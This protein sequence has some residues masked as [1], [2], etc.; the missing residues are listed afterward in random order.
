VF[1]FL[2]TETIYLRL[3]LDRPAAGSMGQEAANIERALHRLCALS[4]GT[5]VIVR[6]RAMRVVGPDPSQPEHG[7][8]VLPPRQGTRINVQIVVE[9]VDK[10]RQ[11]I[12][13]RFA[14]LENW[15]KAPGAPEWLLEVEFNPTTLENGN[16]VLPATI[17]DPETGVL[18]R[19]PSSSPLVMQALNRSGFYFLDEVAKQTGDGDQALFRADTRRA[20]DRGYFE[21][22]R[23]QFCSY[24]QTPSV[25][26]FLQTMVIL[27]GQTIGSGTGV[28][29]LADYLGLL[30]RPFT[31]PNTNV[32][33][34]VMFQKFYGKKPVYSL[35]F[36][37]KMV[38]LAQMRQTT[39][40][41]RTELTTA[42]NNVRFDMTL[43]KLGILD[44]ISAAQTAL[45][46][47]RKD[48]PTLFANF[49]EAFLGPAPRV[50]TAWWLERAIFVLS[51]R[52]R[53]NDLV[54]GSFADWLVPKM[55]KRV[56]RL[57][58]TSRFTSRGLHALLGLSHPVVKAWRELD[59]VQLH[60]SVGA[61]ARLAGIP[62][63]TAY[64]LRQ[65]WL[66]QFGIDIS[67]PFAYY[68]DAL[69]FG[70]MSVTTPGKRAELN[71]AVTGNDGVS[72]VRT[73]RDALKT[74]HST[75]LEVVGAAIAKRPHLMQAQSAL[76]PAT[77]PALVTMAASPSLTNDQR[78]LARRFALAPPSRSSGGAK[79]S[80]TAG[81]PPASAD[82]SKPAALP[83][84]PK[85]I[86]GRSVDRKGEKQRLQR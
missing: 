41:S 32:V 68:R 14:I 3:G 5:T 84:R 80:A 82:S 70:P 15:K 38:R 30:F 2:I 64:N 69:S 53:G 42:R 37:N 4:A 78:R 58:V 86:P 65:K 47:L 21:I 61:V 51:H 11:W 85:A 71:A 54:R 43:H 50:P 79:N 13:L 17:P 10:P 22:V 1:D 56:L 39:S 81:G 23:A 28:V 40:L 62:P 19:F 20:I 26:R 57:D 29:Q 6:G 52:R 72:A 8:C 25:A 66:R 48:D 77:G 35:V 67:V 63:S 7:T 12:S 24:F 45:K 49:A 34:G 76:A 33:T 36:Y 9:P 46:K 59:A 75:R 74:F 83:L 73:L 60:D 55:I 44:L 16:N 27:F 31:N 18:P